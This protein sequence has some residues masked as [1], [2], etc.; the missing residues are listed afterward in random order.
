[1]ALISKKQVAQHEV[2]SKEKWPGAVSLRNSK[3]LRPE[4]YKTTEEG[5]TVDGVLCSYLE[6]NTMDHVFGK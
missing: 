6:P 1:M 3:T 2:F 4:P 5:Q